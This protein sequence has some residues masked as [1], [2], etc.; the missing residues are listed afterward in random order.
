MAINGRDVSIVIDQA[1]NVTVTDSDVELLV[2]THYPRTYVK[3]SKTAIVDIF[4][5]FILDDEELIKLIDDRIA[6]KHSTM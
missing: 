6:L 4:R 5:K 1:D 3:I 2:S